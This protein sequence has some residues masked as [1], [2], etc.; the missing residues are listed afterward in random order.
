MFAGAGGMEANKRNGVPDGLGLSRGHQS[1]TTCSAA[2]RYGTA[3]FSKAS[4]NARPSRSRWRDLE[5]GRVT[6][7]TSTTSRYVA[8]RRR[9]ERERDRHGVGYTSRDGFKHFARRPSAIGSPARR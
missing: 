5:I 9:N 8:S 2:Q 7:G 6:V 1:R 4:A 3:G